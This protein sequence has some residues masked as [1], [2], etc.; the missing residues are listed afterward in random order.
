[1]MLHCMDEVS[2]SMQ[3]PEPLYLAAQL[4]KEMGL[5]GQELP[6]FSYGFSHSTC[7][8][9]GLSLHR[10]DALSPLPNCASETGAG[11]EIGSAAL[12]ALLESEG[13]AALDDVSERLQ[14]LACSFAR[15]QKTAQ[16]MSMGR[17]IRRRSCDDGAIRCGT[18]SL[19]A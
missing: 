3:A 16:P 19:V 18:L 1:M 9:P 15:L 5:Q 14:Q 7:S 12:K 4:V 2:R 10:A 11:D 17:R 6:E 8:S 13:T